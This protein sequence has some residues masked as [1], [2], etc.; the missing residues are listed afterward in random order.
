MEAALNSKIAQYDEDMAG[1]LEIFDL[2]PVHFDL[3]F[4]IIWLIECIF[5]VLSLYQ[6]T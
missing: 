2:L 5:N 1:R 6:L 3:S 4:F